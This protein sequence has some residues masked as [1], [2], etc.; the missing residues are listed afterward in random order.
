MSKQSAGQE[1]SLCPLAGTALCE[2][3]T[4][5]YR[6]CVIGNT[7]SDL[8][9]RDIVIFKIDVFVKDLIGCLEARWTIA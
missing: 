6:I 1:D 2:S 5:H 8:E 7:V 9:E 4:E 3:D